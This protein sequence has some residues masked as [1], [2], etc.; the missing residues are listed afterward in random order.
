MARK[1][2]AQ[3]STSDSTPTV[4]GV[5][6]TIVTLRSEP[7]AIAQEMDV[8][9]VHAV[10]R[11]AESGFTRDLFTLYRDVVVT[12]SHMQNEF[13]KRKLAVLGDKMSVLPWDKTLPA[14]VDA[15][16]AV[17]TMIHNCRSWK[18]ACIHLLDACL[19]PVAVVEKV[20]IPAGGG[21]ALSN[22]VPVPHYL[23]D[24]S[25]GAM[26]IHDVDP[27]SGSILST[28]REVDPARYIVHRGH[29]LTTPDN[30]GGPMRSILFWW[31][32][33]NMSREW[34]GRFLDRYGSP[35]IVAKYPKGDDASRN[36]LKNALAL[37]VKLGG[38]VVTDECM[39]ELVQSASST[40]GDAYDKFLTICQREK[41]KLILGQTISSEAQ[42]T[43]LGSSVATIHESVRQDIREWD[44]TSL[45]DTLRIQL[46][47]QFIQING[48][49]ATTPTL[50]WGS[51]S[52]AEL[53]TKA[54]LLV[55]LKQAGLRL[56]DDAVAILSEQIG[57]ALERDSTA[58]EVGG[59][60]PFLGSYAAQRR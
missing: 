56:T 24:F 53:K 59:L 11:S 16:V 21:F 4:D 1:R 5:R 6:H 42:A 43:G 57:Y 34:W 22:L 29:L 47:A 35:F 9:R 23:L 40:S 38:L 33:G 52:P 20:F 28:S 51:V 2:K 8:D 15:A 14:D 10:I 46:F 41:S 58:Q 30:W 3:D 18:T 49:V 36:T 25:S 31:L 45:G 37:S 17:E 44:S 26:R 39:V 12:D 7:A 19:W 55:S 54:D 32:L 13:S 48:L 60:R 50:T 27:A